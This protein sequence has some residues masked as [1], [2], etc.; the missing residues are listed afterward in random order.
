MNENPKCYWAFSS[1]EKQHKTQICG[2]YTYISYYFINGVIKNGTINFEMWSNFRRCN[3]QLKTINQDILY[4]MIREETEDNKDA[5][6]LT[7]ETDFLTTNTSPV[8]MSLST[9]N[10]AS[11]CPPILALWPSV[12][13]NQPGWT[14]TNK[15]HDKRRD[16]VVLLLWVVLSVIPLENMRIE[17]R[18]KQKLFLITYK[19]NILRAITFRLYNIVK[20]THKF[21]ILSENKL[22]PQTNLCVFPW[23]SRPQW[24]QSSL[25]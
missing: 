21:F 11:L 5:S 4:Y 22:Q 19:Y 17:W 9:T 14:K 18:V 16:R 12:R 3:Y 24:R 23:Q 7:T 13:V 2:Y 20:V 10:Q 1:R 8:A 25:V 15:E 6:T